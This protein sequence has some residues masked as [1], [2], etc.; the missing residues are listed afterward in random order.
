M[1]STF[2]DQKSIYLTLLKRGRD[3]CI[4]VLYMIFQLTI[5]KENVYSLFNT[6]L[7]LCLKG[8][9]QPIKRWKE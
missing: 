8:N 7:L 2:R 1:L 6:T 4:Y 5:Q 9:I 3:F